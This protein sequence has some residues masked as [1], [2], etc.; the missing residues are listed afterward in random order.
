[1]LFF[2][3]YNNDFVIEPASIEDAVDILNI[4][5]LAFEAESRLYDGVEIPPLAQTLEGL[6]ADFSEYAFLRAVVDGQIVGS[7]KCRE[8]AGRVWVGR[9]MVHPSWQ[10]KGI[11]RKLMQAVEEYNPEAVEFELFTGN[12]SLK[13]IALYRS[14]GYEVRDEFLDDKQPGVIL[15]NM[16]KTV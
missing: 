5:Y 7:V 10:N 6:M 3:E 12:K 1:M 4:Q 9:L 16:V 13:N 11:G 14:L 2:M 8:T 15:V